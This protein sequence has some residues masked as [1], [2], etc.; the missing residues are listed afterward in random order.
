[1]VV[2][3]GFGAKLIRGKYPSMVNIYREW[4]ELTESEKTQ[5]YLGLSLVL[6]A[7]VIVLYAIAASRGQDV[8]YFKHRMMIMEQR[9]NNMDVKTDNI[10]QRNADINQRLTAIENTVEE[11]RRVNDANVQE[12]EMLKKRFTPGAAPRR[13]S[14]DP[15]QESILDNQPI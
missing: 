6:G 4:L 8:D 12:L 3:S 9:L 14:W 15:R 5:I 1:M 2:P 7:L 10:S 11:Q 13:S